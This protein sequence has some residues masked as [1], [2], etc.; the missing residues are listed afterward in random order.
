MQQAFARLSE[1]KIDH[2]SLNS[3]MAESWP[4]IMETN[5]FL[6][7]PVYERMQMEEK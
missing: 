1:V 6:G 2:G 7:L 5:T 4:K 3:L